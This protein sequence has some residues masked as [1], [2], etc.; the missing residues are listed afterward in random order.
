MISQDLL[1][2]FALLFI[3]S[4]TFLISKKNPNTKNFL[5]LA[6]FV[7]SILVILDQYLIT[8]PDSTGDA[9]IFEKKAF[10]YSEEYGLGVIKNMTQL[11]SFFISKFISI[12]YTIFERSPMLAK[13]LSVGF[14]TGAVFL[15]YK[16]CF[17][18]CLGFRPK[19]PKYYF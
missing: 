11:D 19:F 17:I 14:G 8:L 18:I 1:G 5:L 15:I 10:L 13:M 16:L 7:R 2:W 6:V 12:F 3:I 4:G 9:V